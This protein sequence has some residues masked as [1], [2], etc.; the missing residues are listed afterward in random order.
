MRDRVHSVLLLVYVDVK[1]DVVSG[2]VWILVKTY[3]I[4]ISFC[5]IMLSQEDLAGFLTTEK[6]GKIFS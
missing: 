5:G 3:S 6:S 1:C 2:N 4:S